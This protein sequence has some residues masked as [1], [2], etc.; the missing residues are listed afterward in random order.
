MSLILP[1]VSSS[2][3]R[4]M[5]ALPEGDTAVVFDVEFADCFVF[6]SGGWEF[7]ARLPELKHTKQF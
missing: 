2:V 7:A 3:T 5:F 6:F 4:C 1:C